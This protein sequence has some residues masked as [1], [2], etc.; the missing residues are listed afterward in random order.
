MTAPPPAVAPPPPVNVTPIQL[1]PANPPPAWSYS[2]PIVTKL[3]ACA[4]CRRSAS[5]AAARASRLATPSAALGA[6]SSS[7][8]A[9][10]A[11]EV[12]ALRQEHETA[13]T[14]EATEADEG[15][16]HSVEADVMTALQEVRRVTRAP[17]G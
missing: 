5:I 13:A 15:L 3:H 6:A 7:R 14:R 2:G 8:D 11:A 1:A 12:A 16:C 10:L 4:N 17:L 9:A